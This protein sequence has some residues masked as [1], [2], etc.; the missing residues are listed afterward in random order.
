MSRVLLTV[1]A[2]G[3]LAAAARADDE[4]LPGP[5]IKWPDIEGLTR[6]KANLFKDKD[7]KFDKDLGYSI[8]YFGDKTSLTATVYV[9]NLGRAKIPSGSGSDAVK[10]EMLDSLNA[11]EANKTNGRYKTLSPLGETIVAPVGKGGPDFR[12]RRYEVDIAKEG[13][14]ITELYV[15][16]YQNHFIKLRTTYLDKDRAECEKQVTKLLESLAAELK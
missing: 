16:A 7:K 12:R 10:A 14:G 2:V 8:A 4:K 9:Y 13:E 6:Q 1:V 11:L 5:K 3:L 15:T